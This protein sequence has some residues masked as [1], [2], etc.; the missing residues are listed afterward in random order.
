MK[1]ATWLG[2]S[3]P[4]DAPVRA[5]FDAR[6]YL[7][8]NRFDAPP[9][10][11]D[12]IDHYMRYGA[13]AG[14]RPHPL[15]DPVYVAEQLG[16][17]K[18]GGD[19]IL[20]PLLAA[21]GP[22]PNRLFEPDL[23]LESL[24]EGVAVEAPPV[25][26]FLETWP[27]HRARFSRVFDPAFYARGLAEGLGPRDN[28]LVHYLSIPPDQ[29][30]DANPMFHAGYYRMATGREVWDPLSDFMAYGAAA[31]HLP[32]PYAADELGEGRPDAAALLAYITLK[33]GRGA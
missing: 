11:G 2:R 14:L 4:E 9:N 3:V 32:N 18:P 31:G 12:P 10:T 26:H 27:D 30:A 16:L 13:R 19:D 24:P 33:T 7:S 17:R 15:V 21:D 23:Y 5:L 8:A 28:P 22:S 6:F 20:A 1:L 29:R 25:L